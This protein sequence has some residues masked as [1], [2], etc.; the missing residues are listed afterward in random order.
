MSDSQTPGTPPGGAAEEPRAPYG[1]APYGQAPDPGGMPPMPSWPDDSAPAPEQPQHVRWAVWLMYAGAA[2]SLIS[3]FFGFGDRADLR[4]QAAKQLKASGT[5]VTPD[6]VD[7]AVNVSL[8]LSVVI[9]LIAVA[10]WLL[11]AWKS[12]QG[13]NWAR[14]LGTILG[15]LNVLLT[16][17]SLGGASVT[18]VT[19][20]GLAGVVSILMAAVALVVVVLLWTTPS[21][22]WFDLHRAQTRR[23]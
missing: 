3:I 12:G 8:A 2:L 23:A 6:Q 10:L 5:K 15:V 17:M 20:A 4:S 21:R 14:M 22:S 11:I 1:Q 16:A 9:G 7:A 13:R 18:G 19:G